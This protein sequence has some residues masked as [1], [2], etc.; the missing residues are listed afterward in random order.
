MTYNIPFVIGLFTCPPKTIS[1]GICLKGEIDSHY[2][3]KDKIPNE[4]LPKMD[5]QMS[6]YPLFLLSGGGVLT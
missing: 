1:D 3:L 5:V 4:K 6:T 2:D